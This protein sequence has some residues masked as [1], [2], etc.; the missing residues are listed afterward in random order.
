MATLYRNRLYRLEFLPVGTYF[1]T[2]ANQTG[3]LLK[4]NPC[5]ARVKL[6]NAG[7]GRRVVFKDADGTEHDFIA[8][9]SGERDWAPGTEVYVLEVPQKKDLTSAYRVVHS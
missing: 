7:G 1:R 2:P 3:W 9:T 6:E 5:R 8:T 4:C